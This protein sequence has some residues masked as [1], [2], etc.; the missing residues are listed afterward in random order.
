MSSCTT[1]LR[2]REMY[3]LTCPGEG[4]GFKL[5]LS[6]DMAAA[7]PTASQSASLSSLGAR[8]S[9]IWG[10]QR[11]ASERTRGAAPEPRHSSSDRP[12]VFGH[13]ERAGHERPGTGPP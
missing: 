3:K 7:A 1:Q 13:A 11:T 9:V 4:G 12:I 8:D 10:A 5:H 2:Q 6:K